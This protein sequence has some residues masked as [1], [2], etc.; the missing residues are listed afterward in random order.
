MPPKADRILIATRNKGKVK[1]FERLFAPLGISV[2]SLAEYPQLPDVVEDGET[3]AD[4]ALKKAKTIA[5]QLNV[6]TLADDSGLRVADLDGA[7]GV[8]SARYAGEPSDD[9]AN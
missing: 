9:G 8:Y 2:D 3:F 4:N 7:P 5:D 6:P 1:E